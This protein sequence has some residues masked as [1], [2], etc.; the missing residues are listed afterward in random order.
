[1]LPAVT[2]LCTLSVAL[3]REFSFQTPA[4]FCISINEFR[5]TNIHMIAFLAYAA[6]IDFPVLVRRPPHHREPT[7]FLVCQIA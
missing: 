7:E 5:A 4:G 1:V 6:P 3:H 2:M